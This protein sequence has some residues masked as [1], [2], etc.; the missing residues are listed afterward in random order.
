MEQV[1]TKKINNSIVPGQN[2]L[3][4]LADMIMNQLEV[5][6]KQE[7]LTLQPQFSSDFLSFSSLQKEIDETCLGKQF[8][9]N[10]QTISNGI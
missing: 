7:V 5:Q 6:P 3:T 1:L 4:A 2:K 10:N 8:S 9:L